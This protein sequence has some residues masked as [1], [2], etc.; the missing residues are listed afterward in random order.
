[1][2]TYNGTSIA[3]TPGV[4]SSTTIS[5]D[6]SQFT[7][8]SSSANCVTATHTA[9]SGTCYGVHASTA[10][11][12]GVAVY[13]NAT[14]GSG[15]CY[16][17]RGDCNSGDGNGVLGTNTATFGS[18][19][20]GNATASTTTTYGV[21]GVASSSSGTG[22]RGSCTYSG[23][24]TTYGLYGTAGST[25]GAAVYGNSSNGSGSCHGVEG[26]TASTSANGVLG[27]NT[28]A[29]GSAV[30]G[31]STGT[32][33]QG[34]GVNG[35]ATASTFGVGVQGTGGGW[36]VIGNG[37][38]YGVYALNGAGGGYGV[39]GDDGGFAAAFA[40]FGQATG[41]G[42]YAGYFSGDLYV[43]GSIT[44]GT[45]DFRID[46]PLDPPNMWLVHS[47]VES[48]ERTNVYS[49]TV[50]TDGNGEAE[51]RMPAYFEALNTDFRYQLTAIGGPAPGLH[52]KSEVRG[53][54]F[55]IA[56]AGPGQRVSW[57]VTGVRQDA[58]S[59][60]NPLR[61]ECE[62]RPTERGLFAFPAA[63]GQPAERGIDWIHQQRAQTRGRLP[64]PA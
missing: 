27:T 9:A 26:V 17:V 19:V 57:Q 32:S 43:S 2:T 49:G 41:T 44:A 62:K 34:F 6:A 30:Y 64:R 58:Y 52:I 53:N 46:H 59:R 48:P 42:S 13:G 56:G 39:F 54:C 20:Y 47:C 7:G 8:S 60:A 33:G 11:T 61:V 35:V 51:V 50:T 4:S 12:S 3:G 21:Y 25:S 10:S 38:T 22:V 29:G 55:V 23:T 28:A 18:A 14:G 1:M 16:G 40:V 45:K 37:G 36:G 31:H 5:E 24:G 63:H 15:S